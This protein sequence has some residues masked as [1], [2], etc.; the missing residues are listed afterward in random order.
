METVV[1]L[2]NSGESASIPGESPNAGDVVNAPLTLVPSD[3]ATLIGISA[4]SAIELLPS[5]IR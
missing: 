3:S 4:E 2:E 1:A 5:A